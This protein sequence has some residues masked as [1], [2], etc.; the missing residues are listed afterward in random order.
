LAG[1]AVFM[2]AVVALVA[3]T[4]IMVRQITGRTTGLL[5]QKEQF[6]LFGQAQLEVSRQQTQVICNGTL[7][8]YC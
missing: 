6:A 8:S 5:D 7:Y 4:K 3:T 1:L 2:E